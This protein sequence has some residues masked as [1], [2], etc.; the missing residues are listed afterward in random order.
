MNYQ[1]FLNE[2]IYIRPLES[3]KVHVRLYF[4]L[5]IDRVL[6]Q[7]NEK[8]PLKSTRKLKKRNDSFHRG[9]KLG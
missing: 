9:E 3:G 8:N 7:W 1:R 2:Y 6:S 4:I 5:M